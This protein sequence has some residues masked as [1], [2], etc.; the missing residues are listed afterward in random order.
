M[1]TRIT[2]KKIRLDT[3]T[4][5]TNTVFYLNS[6]RAAPSGSTRGSRLFGGPPNSSLRYPAFPGVLLI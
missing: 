2:L 1:V 4:Q 5:I 6:V 3:F